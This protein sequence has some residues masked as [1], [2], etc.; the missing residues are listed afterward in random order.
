MIFRKIGLLLL[1]C[2]LLSCI[3]CAVT[4]KKQM[5]LTGRIS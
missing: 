5:I 4:T 2:I 3:G 1:C